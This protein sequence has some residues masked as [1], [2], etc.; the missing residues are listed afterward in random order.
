[1]LSLNLYV[2][3]VQVYRSMP[4]MLPKLARPHYLSNMNIM[5][6]SVINLV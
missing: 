4:M 1:M 5:G 6:Y 3:I 2:A